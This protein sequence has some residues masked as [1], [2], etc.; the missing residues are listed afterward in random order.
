MQPSRLQQSIDSERIE[1]SIYRKNLDTVTLK[2]LHVSA[3]RLKL[4][5]WGN[6]LESKGIVLSLTLIDQN[7]I[8]DPVDIRSCPKILQPL[9]FLTYNPFMKHCS[10]M[11]LDHIISPSSIDY[12]T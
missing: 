4:E 3:E 8:V 6:S 12:S 10:I 7:N 1:C 2:T 5:R 9:Q 11:E